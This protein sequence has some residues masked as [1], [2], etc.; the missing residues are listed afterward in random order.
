MDI[1][2]LYSFVFFVFIPLGLII[3]HTLLIP[4]FVSMIDRHQFDAEMA[5]IIEKQFNYSTRK[6]KIQTFYPLFQCKS[7]TK[8]D[9]YSV[10]IMRK[11]S[12]LSPSG[13]FQH[14]PRSNDILSNIYA[15][16]IIIFFTTW[17]FKKT[18]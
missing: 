4:R 5:R 13:S 6:K 11:T 18:T 1:S 7:S 3:S 2:V 12:I 17:I 14:H 9:N 8:L 15:T 16:T 10:L